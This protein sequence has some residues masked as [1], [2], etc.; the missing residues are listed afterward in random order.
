MGKSKP[1]WPMDTFPEGSIEE[2]MADNC[3]TR[4]RWVM[5]RGYRALISESSYSGG[6]LHKVLSPT[7]I[8]AEQLLMIN[9]GSLHMVFSSKRIQAEQGGRALRVCKDFL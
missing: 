1:S 7:K 6:G 4:H 2:G 8:Q 3:K 5:Q 9:R